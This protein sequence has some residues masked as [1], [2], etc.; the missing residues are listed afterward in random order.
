MQDNKKGMVKYMKAFLSIILTLCIVG[1]TAI[2]GTQIYKKQQQQKIDDTPYV[3]QGEVIT[4][5]ETAEAKEE[6][7][8][9]LQKEVAKST[10]DKEILDKL[11]YEIEKNPDTVAWIK[12]P[13]TTIDNSILQYH[14]NEYYQR[15]DERK[16]NNIYGCYFADYESSLSTRDN[17]KKNTV[18]YGHSD[19]KDNPD[20]QRFSQLFKFTDDKFADTHKE[21]HIT[22]VNEDFVFEIFSVFYTDI[23][24]DYI[25]V[26][27]D[28][29]AYQEIL[30][31]ALKLSIRDYNIKPTVQD[32]ILTLS[33]CSVKYHQDGTGRFVIMGRLK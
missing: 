11:M 26:N 1:I 15:R 19:L 30:D 12:I 27:M 3:P 8:T 18:I 4:P 24:F 32:K 13:D 28:D 14:N 6:N 33:T 9:E 20:G 23:N 29:K 2:V 21:I 10:A 31:T 5:E 25:R 7:K 16:K 17:L 22:T